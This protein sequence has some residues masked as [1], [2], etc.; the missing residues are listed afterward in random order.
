M[1]VQSSPIVAPTLN[2]NS[3]SVRRDKYTY[4]VLMA[5]VFPAASGVF[6]LFSYQCFQKGYFK[7]GIVIGAY[8][9][10]VTTAALLRARYHIRRSKSVV[11]PT[12]T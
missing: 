11:T 4:G 6:G 3:A 9:V 2:Y 12:I 8:G 10:A 1:P 7:M 5:S